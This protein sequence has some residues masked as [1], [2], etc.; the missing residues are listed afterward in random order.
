MFIYYIYI[1][2]LHWQKHD[3][4]SVSI[5]PKGCVGNEKTPIRTNRGL[6]E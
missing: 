5:L 3:R 2:I 1:C 6:E 4:N